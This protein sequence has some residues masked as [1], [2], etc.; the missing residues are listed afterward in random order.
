MV[1]GDQGKRR[2]NQHSH[3]FGDWETMPH[4][5]CIANRTNMGADTSGRT[6]KAP[7]AFGTQQQV[8]I[9]AN[10]VINRMFPK[11]RR[12]RQCGPSHE[13]NASGRGG[14]GQQPTAQSRGRREGFS[15]G[16]SAAAIR[17]TCRSIDRFAAAPPG[18]FAEGR[19]VIDFLGGTPGCRR[20]PPIEIHFCVNSDVVG[21]RLR[22]VGLV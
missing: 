1:Q 7:S 15:R 22:L 18:K 17:I 11:R 9:S 5:L 13:S 12:R 8:A 3:R 4:L 6:R 10:D 19:R 14:N 16:D 21:A 20:L 2:R